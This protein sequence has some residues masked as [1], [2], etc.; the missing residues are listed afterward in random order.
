MGKE[1]LDSSDDRSPPSR[2]LYQTKTNKSVMENLSNS[3]FGA[4]V[5]ESHVDDNV[6]FLKIFFFIIFFFLK[7]GNNLRNQLD[8]LQ[9]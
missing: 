4:I 7:K 1:K 2:N 8:K 5:K 3:W 9:N 6:K